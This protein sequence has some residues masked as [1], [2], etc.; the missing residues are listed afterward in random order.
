MVRRLY[1]GCLT[2][3]CNH[4]HIG[5]EVSLEGGDG[6]ELS[7]VSRQVI[8]YLWSCHTKHLHRGP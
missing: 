6:G 2:I 8:P 7:I 1:I 5:I 4:K 3:L